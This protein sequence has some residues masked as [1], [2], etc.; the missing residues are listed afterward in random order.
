MEMLK[1]GRMLENIKEILK[2][3]LKQ[4][5][6]F[7]SSRQRDFCDVVDFLRNKPETAPQSHSAWL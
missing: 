2:M 5:K 7:F 3:I 4:K 6:G 1:D